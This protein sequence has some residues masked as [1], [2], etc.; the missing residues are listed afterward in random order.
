MADAIRRNRTLVELSLFNN[1]I[2]V[3][4]GRAIAE[5]IRMNDSLRS[6]DL[7]ENGF[8]SQTAVTLLQV[9]G[10]RVV[11]DE[12]VRGLPTLLRATPFLHRVQHAATPL[13]RFQQR[14]SR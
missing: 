13:F 2:G 10:G 9:S 5:A 14:L 11:L 4:G 7:R 3:D 1:A 8:D 6:L 12:E